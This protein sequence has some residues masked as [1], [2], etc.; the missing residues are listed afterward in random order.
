MSRT[1][2]HLLDSYLRQQPHIQMLT[3]IFLPGVSP[4]TIAQQEEALGYA[5]HD[6][7]K[8][9]FMAHNGGLMRWIDRNE[10]CFS[11]DKHVEDSDPE[12]DLWS[13][14]D[15]AFDYDPLQPSGVIFIPAFET[16]FN[17]WNYLQN[18]IDPD[19]EDRFL[20]DIWMENDL[21]EIASWID[22]GVTFKGNVYSSYASLLEEMRIFNYHERDGAV[23]LHLE[24][25]NSDPDVVYAEA[26]SLGEY[27]RLMP[28][29]QYLKMLPFSLGEWWAHGQMFTR[30]TQFWLNEYAKPNMP[31]ELPNF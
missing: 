30:D 24:P 5:V 6:D 14:T 1:H 21:P 7:I 22:G 3:S 17:P 31:F 2:L 25:N 8:S 4:E 12:K 26:F 23:L 10:A 18:G 9:F 28:L 27:S 29:T 15:Q 20:F 16:I 19:K 11:L 13:A